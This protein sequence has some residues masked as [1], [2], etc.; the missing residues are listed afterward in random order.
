MNTYYI[1]VTA[2]RKK[3]TTLCR[4]IM[5]APSS[6]GYFCPDEKKLSFRNFL[7]VEMSLEFFE[8]SRDWQFLVVV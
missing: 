5:R 6:I 1:E 2:P 3:T 4:E 7:H 8:T